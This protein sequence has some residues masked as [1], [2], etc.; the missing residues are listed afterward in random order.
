MTDSYRKDPRPSITQLAKLHSMTPAHARVEWAKAPSEAM[1]LGSAVHIALLQP[2][3]FDS[4]IFVSDAPV[5]E[6]TGKPYGRDTKAFG[7]WEMAIKQEHGDKILISTEQADFIDRM[8]RSVKQLDAWRLLRACDM[9]EIPLYGQIAGVQVRGRPDAVC[10]K[11][12]APVIIDLKTSKSASRSWFEKSIADF[13]YGFQAAGY[14]M[15]AAQNGIDCRHYLFIVVENQRPFGSAC[16]RLNDEVISWYRPK[17]EAAAR[18]YEE[19]VQTDS[20][21][22]YPY[23][24]QEIGLPRWHE[25]SRQ[26]A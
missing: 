26:T 10:S 2:E 25:A 15:L 22:A 13:D 6:R 18:L 14:A 9:K 8:V 17:V 7:D 3:D 23:E 4:M 11:K 1:E 12:Y 20:W 19:C 21:P 16:F 24:T 5:N